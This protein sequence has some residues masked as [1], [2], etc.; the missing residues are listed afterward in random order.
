MLSWPGWLT[1]SGRFTHI[2]GHPSATGRAQ[3]REST[4]AEDRRSTSATQPPSTLRTLP[5]L[6]KL[7]WRPE[8]PTRW[9]VNHSWDVPE[10]LGE[11][12]GPVPAIRPAPGSA[13]EPASGPGRK[14]GVTTNAAAGGD[15]QSATR[16]RSR[17]SAFFT[18][19]YDN[20]TV[21]LDYCHTAKHNHQKVP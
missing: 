2:S 8:G 19:T 9:L 12:Q 20:I 6:A 21:R 15:K 13:T 18:S 1:H 11:H 10:P 4:P 5:N 3:D 7:Q 14:L 16:C 17:G